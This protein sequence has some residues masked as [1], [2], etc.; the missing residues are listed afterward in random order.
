[1]DER[2]SYSISDGGRAQK[3]KDKHD[4]H[5]NQVQQLARQ[6]ERL[7]SQLQA[8]D[9]MNTSHFKNGHLLV[10]DGSHVSHPSAGN[11]TPNG[12]YAGNS[13]FIQTAPR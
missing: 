10:M 3:E 6:V 12:S 5:F 8:R 4:D 1:M 7:A 2:E 9:P 13:G 11:T